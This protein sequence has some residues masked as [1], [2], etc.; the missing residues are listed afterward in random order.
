MSNY[1][2]ILKESI[3]NK[4]LVNEQINIHSNIISFFKKNPNPNDKQIHDLSDE[5]NID[6]SELENHI[7]MLLSNFVNNVG[8]HNDVPDSKFDQKEL[9]MGIGVEKEHTDDES[10]AKNI[11]KDHLSEIPDYYTRLTKMEK[12]AGIED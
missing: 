9:K 6:P 5:L 11:A 8:K 12:D 4:K 3:G 7:Y 2:S 10:I 1:L